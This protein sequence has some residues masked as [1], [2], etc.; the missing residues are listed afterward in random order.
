MRCARRCTHDGAHLTSDRLN[1]SYL[2]AGRAVGRQFARPAF[3]AEQLRRTAGQIGTRGVQ[4]GAALI[5]VPA[6]A[7]AELVEKHVGRD[8]RRPEPAL[9]PAEEREPPLAVRPIR[10]HDDDRHRRV[11]AAGA[12]PDAD[13]DVAAADVAAAPGE[14]LEAVGRAGRRVHGLGP[15]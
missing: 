3:Q 4:S 9:R 1:P 12:D 13:A 8:E 7:P 14:G 15:R 10:Q 5:R 6:S 2:H 11:V